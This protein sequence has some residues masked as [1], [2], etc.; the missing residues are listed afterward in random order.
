MGDILLLV[1]EMWWGILL[2]IPIIL[3]GYWYWRTRR[4][5]TVKHEALF[6]RADMTLEF[7]KLTATSGFLVDEKRKCAWFLDPDALME[8][9]D[10][11]LHLVL[12]EDSAIPHFPGVA[13]VD[14]NDKAREYRG[15]RTTIAEQ[16]LDQA[17]L[18][19]EED[20]KH[21]WFSR[22]G[23]VAVTSFCATI[24]ILVVAGLA[25]AFF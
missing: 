4:T 1:K 13:T 7:V 11:S 6:L 10:E 19:A 16:H 20:P 25:S 8:Q 22:A 17:L 14:R 18:E 2:W 24:G 15:V 9:T 3:G 12:T 21:D 23:F 5:K